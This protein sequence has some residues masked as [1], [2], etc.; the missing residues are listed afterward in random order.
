[1]EVIHTVALSQNFTGR[2]ALEEEHKCSV[3]WSIKAY[4]SFVQHQRKRQREENK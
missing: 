3:L 2:K 1:M 4:L